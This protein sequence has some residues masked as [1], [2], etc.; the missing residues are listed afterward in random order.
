MRHAAER[1]RAGHR[2]QLLLAVAVA[3]LRGVGES[4]R[5]RVHADAMRRE[6]ERH[7]ARHRYDA[8]LARRVVHAAHGAADRL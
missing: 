4:R 3:R 8:A 5:D 2:R 7:R 6:L 1:N